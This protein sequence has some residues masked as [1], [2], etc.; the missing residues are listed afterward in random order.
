MPRLLAALT[1]EHFTLQGARSQTASESA[2]R[3]SLYILS[4]SSALVAMGFIQASKEWASTIVTTA[5]P[6]SQST[7]RMRGG[8]AGGAAVSGAGADVTRPP[9]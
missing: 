4:V 5:I 6:R 1:T 8:R 3:A 9:G 7:T 2:S